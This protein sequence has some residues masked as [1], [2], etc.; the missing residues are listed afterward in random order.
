MVLVEKR[1]QES[2]VLVQSLKLL[3]DTHE[4]AEVISSIS[5]SS[6]IFYT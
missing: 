5:N 1:R 3:V 2:A 6:T 4:Q